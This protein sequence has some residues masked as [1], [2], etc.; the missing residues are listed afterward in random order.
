MV[1]DVVWEVVALWESFQ[2]ETGGKQ[3][4]RAVD[5]FGANIAEGYG[6]FHYGEK[7]QFLYYA[8]G[9]LYETK[10]WLNRGRPR[11]LFSEEIAN[12][13]AQK[14]SNIARQLNA[15]AKTTKNQRSKPSQTKIRERGNI[16]T[17][18]VKEEIDDWGLFTQEEINS[19]ATLNPS[20]SA[21]M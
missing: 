3:M 14:L 19:L 1:A 7:L 21:I 5:S 18:N 8:R 15:Y 4:M 12:D 6:R 20:N 17:V 2:R 13:I 11:N 10:Y 16:Y 9:S